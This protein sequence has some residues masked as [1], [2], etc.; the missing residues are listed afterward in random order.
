MSIFDKLIHQ[1]DEYDKE[2]LTM[3]GGFIKQLDHRSGKA[4]P[5][6]ASADMKYARALQRARLTVKN[7][8]INT[9]YNLT[10]E[11]FSFVNWKLDTDTRYKVRIPFY[12]LDA[13][14]DVKVNGRRRKTMRERQKIYGYAVWLLGQQN[15]KSYC[16]PNC[17]GTSTVEE[18]L[19]GCPYCSTRFLMND[20]YPKISSVYT[21]KELNIQKR[22]K[23][24]VLFFAL[25]VTALAFC[26]NA[27]DYIS[28][29]NGTY[30]GHKTFEMIAALV[31]TPFVGIFVGVLFAN[32][33]IAFRKFGKFIVTLGLRSDTR[34]AG[35]LVPEFMR[36]YEPNFSLDY[37]VTKLVSLTQ[38]MLY[39]DDLNNC[40]IYNGEPMENKWK[41]LIDARYRGFLK[42]NECRAE[43][44][45]LYADAE[46]CMD[47][48][49]CRGGKIK[50]KN[51][52]FRLVLRKNAAAETDYG[53]SIHSINC[54]SCGASFDASK[55][56][57]CPNCGNAYALDSYDWVVIK[58]ESC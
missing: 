47:D 8:E 37:F 27:K 31:I 38:V 7:A 35:R 23:L 29:F 14:T 53:F 44:G 12:E 34:N 10:P 39:T 20:L 6:K 33:A 9:E 41:N 3:L 46:V 58:F 5:D 15:K 17:G 24:D 26:L 11:T 48:V 54:R 56:K 4:D 28:I 55:Q 16:C 52:R 30:Q 1:K 49:Y 25:A 18:L 42:I 40:A 21:Q 32:L 22:F 19:S 2:S 36:R 45:Y 50:R 51:E 57:R 13:K 43:N